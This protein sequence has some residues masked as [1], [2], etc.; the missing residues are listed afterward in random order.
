MGR[1]HVGTENSTSITLHYEDHGIGA[2]VV[3]ISAFPLTGQS[4]EKQLG[5]AAARPAGRWLSRHRVRPQRIREVK[6]AWDGL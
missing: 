5:E 6:P 2:P 1:I 4:W 3:L